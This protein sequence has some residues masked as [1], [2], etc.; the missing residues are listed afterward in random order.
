MVASGMSQGAIPASKFCC[1]E[2]TVKLGEHLNYIMA[3]ML[4]V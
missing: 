2:F 1:T 4:I 3:G